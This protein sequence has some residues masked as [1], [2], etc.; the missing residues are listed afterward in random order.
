MHRLRRQQIDTKVESDTITGMIVSDRFLKEAMVFVKPDLLQAEHNRRIFKWIERYY[1]NYGVAPNQEIQSIFEMEQWDLEDAESSVISRF[2]DELSDKYTEYEEFNVDYHLD[3]AEN[4]FKGRY[5]KQHTDKVQLLWEEGEI[6]EAEAEIARFSNVSR[7][8]SSWVDPFSKEAIAKTFEDE[9]EELFTLPGMMG[10]LLGPLKRG[11]LVSIMAPNKRGK[12]NFMFWMSLMATTYR[13]KVAA[14][15]LEMSSSQLNMRMYKNITGMRDEGTS[16]DVVIPVFDCEKNQYGSCNMAERMNELT[17][18]DPEGDLPAYSPDIPYT[19][20]DYCRRLHYDKFAPAVWYTSLRKEA[21]NQR[22]A[23]DVIRKY[24]NQYGKSP[25]RFMSYP[26]NSANLKRIRSDLD[27]LEYSEGFVPDLIVIDYADILGAEDNRMVGR[28]AINETWK[29]LKALPQY[30]NC[31]C[32]TA[33][34]AN[35]LAIE[36]ARVKQTNTGEDI[37]KL[38]HVDGMM[39]L[40]QTAEEKRRGYMRVGLIAH[41]H[42]EFDELRQLTVLQQLRIGQVVL[43]SDWS[44]LDKEE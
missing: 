13:L 26:M 20:C 27:I 41:R 38:N 7:I 11:W 35:R 24:E 10:D 42:K 32:L 5:I 18:V 16:E 19:S 2:L 37:R 1:D 39:V 15:S 34:Q 17:L 3:K 36:A 25:F 9:G 8:T 44:I 28:D 22:R 43:D 29:E 6:D 23:A 30:R 12:T 33:T 14:F 4:Y 31:L 40:N 21:I